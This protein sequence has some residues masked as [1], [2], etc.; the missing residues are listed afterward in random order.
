M[1]D[2]AFIGGD[3]GEAFMGGDP[4]GVRLRF[5]TMLTENT[6]EARAFRAITC[7]AIEFGC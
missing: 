1:E 4:G 6:D 5:D 3:P 2:E 7:A